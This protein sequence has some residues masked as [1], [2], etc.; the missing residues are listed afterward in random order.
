MSKSLIVHSLH[1]PQEHLMRTII[2]LLTILVPTIMLVRPSTAIQFP[3]GRIA[4][5]SPPRLIKAES[6]YPQPNM[7][8]TYYFTLDIPA[9]AGEPLK[10][11]KIVQ[12]ENLETIDYKDNATRVFQG[13][14]QERGTQVP[15]VSIGGP[16][17]PGM[18]TVVFDSPV[19]PGETVT[20]ALKAK[21][22]PTY[23]G[24]YQFG[25]TAYPAGEKSIGQFL[26]Y[27]RVEFD[28]D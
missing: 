19:E 25:V 16:T 5:D 1:S 11:V 18:I 22:N 17:K 12:R 7:P 28:T 20:V 6:N 8:S 24:I 15:L 26:G 2:L 4:F 27:T 3:D 9:N 13:N 10:A 14:R 23:G 21:R